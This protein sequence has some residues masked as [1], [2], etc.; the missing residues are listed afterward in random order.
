MIKQ[1]ITICLLISFSINMKAQVSSENLFYM[2]DTP[3]S[4]A[5]FKKNLDQ[6]S[7]VAPAAFL[8]SKECV[9]SG[10]LDPRVLELAKVNK[11]KVMPLVA[12]PGFTS[13]LLHAILTNPL[14][15]KR[16]IRMMLTYAKKYHLDGWQFDLE[17]LNI[18]DRDSFT[19]YFK[20]TAIALHQAGLQLSAALVHAVENVG[21]PTAYHRFLYENWR[22]GYA[23]K[24]LSE[25]GDF[26]SIMAYDHHTRR[27]PPG[28]VAGV[29]W[30]ERI[31]QYLLSEGVAPEKI[32]LGI[33]D[34]S[35]HWFPDYTEERGGFSNAQQ[36]GYT[37]VQHLLGKCKAP[38][39]WNEKAGCN[40]TFWDNDGV[41]E[42]MYIEDA[43]SLKAKLSV[44]EKY[45]LRGISVWVLG[46]EDPE[47]WTVLQ[48]EITAK[49]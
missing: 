4:F 11:I 46:K 20:E 12:N 30:V 23:F 9:I 13:E 33:P 41:Y 10:S 29:D 31:V 44:L 14:A 49:K 8:I 34:Y 48:K 45:K 2:T 36:I 42:Y 40:Y 26:I 22:A 6:I 1:V 16:S 3:E 28:P 39:I 37:T 17:G 35:V 27:T 15:R 25:A 7:I 5:S 38:L 21:G 47:F 43:Q 18:K 24:E 19:T 32:S